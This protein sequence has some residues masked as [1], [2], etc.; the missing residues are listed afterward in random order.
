MA[1]CK[2]VIMAQKANVR[3][4]SLTVTRSGKNIGVAPLLQM[5]D[6]VILG[7]PDSDGKTTADL[8]QLNDD[9]QVKAR[10]L[11]SHG[12]ALF[13]DDPANKGP[14]ET[15]AK[16]ITVENDRIAKDAAL[17][18]PVSI[19]TMM[20]SMASMADQVATLTSLVA[21]L[22]GKKLTEKTS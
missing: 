2:F 14:L 10:H 12:M 19:D 6:V 8:T 3:A 7:T 16:K 22:T 5:G 4:L 17:N 11:L 18:K 15:L 21:Q 20:Q 9:D 1:A 13:A